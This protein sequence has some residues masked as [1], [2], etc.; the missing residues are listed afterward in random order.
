MKLL[1]FLF[2]LLT[3][4]TLI[5]QT[6]NHF[7]L[8]YTG[9]YKG[10]LYLE[11]PKTKN[12]VDFQLEIASTSSAL[13]FN[14]KT[15]YLVNDSVVNTKNYDLKLDT[16]SKDGNRYI[17]DE[18]DGILIYETNVENS[19]YSSYSVEGYLYYVKTTYTKK[20]IDFELQVFSM[21]DEV[22]SNS[23]LDK[24]GKSY[25]VGT[26]A[27]ITVQHGRLKRAKK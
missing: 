3:T 1:L 14:T 26:Q 2:S 24:E 10:V 19:F 16:T 15:S 12:S 13:I 20:Y 8:N 23:S 9:K 4:C 7:L 25:K 17:L 27:F 5:S 11:S 18:K 6:K 21:I 22:I